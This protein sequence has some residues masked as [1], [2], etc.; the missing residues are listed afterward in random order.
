MIDIEWSREQRFGAWRK[1]VMN[2]IICM[3]DEMIGLSIENH[4][5]REEVEWLKSSDMSGCPY[6]EPDKN[7][8]VEPLRD[9]AYVHA[10]IDVKRK[11]LDIEIDAKHLLHV[12]ID[13]KRCPKCGR[14]L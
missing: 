1:E 7:D 14:V 4:N 9:D 6:C 12:V 3:S 10:E 13:I 11:K 8:V 5:L 2:D